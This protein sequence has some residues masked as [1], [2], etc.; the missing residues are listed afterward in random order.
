MG[1]NDIQHGGDHYKGAKF[2]HWDLISNNNIGYL[3]G[4]GS[5]YPTRWRKKNG[6]EDVQKAMH[7]CDKIVEKVYENG[8]KPSGC[9]PQVDLFR[10]FGENNI[11]DLD[12]QEAIT[13]LC[14]WKFVDE[15]IVARRALER[16]LEKA[17]NFKP[18]G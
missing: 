6:V 14:T 9:A 2:Q 10:F 16:L 18:A 4:C 12:E 7:Y 17:V 5:K 15:I 13:L 1:A 11:T 8:Y 3:E